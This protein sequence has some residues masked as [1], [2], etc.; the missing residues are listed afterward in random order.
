MAKKHK[1]ALGAYIVYNVLLWSWE[2]RRNN[3]YP[4]V[5]VVSEHRR[6]HFGKPNMQPRYRITVIGVFDDDRDSDIGRQFV[7]KE[8]DLRAA[9]ANDK[10][11]IQDYI[12]AVTSSNLSRF[13]LKEDQGFDGIKVGCNIVNILEVERMLSNYKRWKKLPLKQKRVVANKYGH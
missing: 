11:V 9:K 5:A 12:H 10:K 4:V 13:V 2:K 3:K 8:S 1:Y 6:D 7:V